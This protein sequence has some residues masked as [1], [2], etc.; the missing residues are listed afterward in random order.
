MKIQ[1]D[2]NKLIKLEISNDKEPLAQA[3]ALILGGY[4][5]Q[6]FCVK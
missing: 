2:Y 3:V 4:N 5:L 6:N 1:P